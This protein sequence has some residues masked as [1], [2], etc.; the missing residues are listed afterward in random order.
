M[1]CK[2]SLDMVLLL[3]HLSF[4]IEEE[5][6]PPDPLRWD[7]LVPFPNLQHDL[8]PFRA[9]DLPF[10]DPSRLGPSG[11]HH[12]SGHLAPEALEFADVPERSLHARR[13]DFQLVGVGHHVLYVQQD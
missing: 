6:G 11:P 2:S 10:E 8:F 12:D 1:A 3:L 7:P 9:Q 4:E 5:V 13:G